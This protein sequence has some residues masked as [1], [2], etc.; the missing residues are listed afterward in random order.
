M[1]KGQ[2][3]NKFTKFRTTLV[4]GYARSPELLAL[5][6]LSI[7]TP[8]GEDKEVHNAVIFEIESMVGS[9]RMHLL[10]QAIAKS[11]NTIS[12]TMTG[13]TNAPKKEEGAN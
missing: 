8:I 13:E 4:S 10:A 7:L 12:N 11:I 2:K 9:G 1:R 3:P 5:R 6:V